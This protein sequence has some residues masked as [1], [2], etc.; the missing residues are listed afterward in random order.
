ME[1]NKKSDTLGA[2]RALVIDDNKI[3]RKIVVDSLD[4]LGVQNISAFEEAESALEELR[5]KVDTDRY[6][7]VVFLDWRLPGMDGLELL[8]ICRSDKRFEEMA[9]VMLTGEKQEKKVIE[10]GAAGATFYITKPATLKDIAEGVDNIL[11]WF[12]INGI[13]IVKDDREKDRT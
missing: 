8:K 11:E 3:M 7:N 9:I 12:D 10:T 6:Y 1:A 5:S 4:R 13:T 2:L